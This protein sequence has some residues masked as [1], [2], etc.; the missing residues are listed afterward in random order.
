MAALSV[1]CGEAG[2]EIHAGVEIVGD[3]SAA[4]DGCLGVI[5]HEEPLWERGV[6]GESGGHAVAVEG[7]VAPVCGEEGDERLQQVRLVAE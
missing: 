4:G 6:R 2:A 3:E 1:E 5:E 7:L